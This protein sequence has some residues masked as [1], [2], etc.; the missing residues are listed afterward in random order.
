MPGPTAQR[1]GRDSWEAGAPTGQLRGPLCGSLCGLLARCLARGQLD[2]PIVEED[3]ALASAISAAH[4]FRVIPGAAHLNEGP[5]QAEQVAVLSADWF[6][7]KLLVPAQA[8]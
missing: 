5:G 4:E 7:Q 1:S 8:W 3:R 6:T 2:I